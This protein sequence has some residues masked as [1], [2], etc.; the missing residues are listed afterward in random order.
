MSGEA[1]G[2]RPRK[3][4]GGRQ[5]G[6]AADHPD[7]DAAVDAYLRHLSPG[8]RRVALGR[9]R[10]VARV[11]GQ[12]EGVAGIVAARRW[13][14]LAP[15]HLA[16]VRDGLLATGA[17]P[18]TVNVTLATLRGI[19]RAA[20]D[21]GLLAA[22]TEQRLGLVRGVPIAHTPRGRLATPGEVRALF[23]ACLQ[24]HTVAGLRDAAILYSFSSAGLADAEAATL[25]V[26]DYAARPPALRIAAR[27]TAR[28]RRP[29]RIPLTGEPAAAFERW[30]AVRGSQP[31][32]LFLPLGRAGTLRG[33][34][35]TVRALAN[36]VRR[37]ARVAGLAPLTPQDLRRSAIHELFE[38]G[39]S[40]SAVWQRFGYASALTIARYDHRDPTDPRWWPDLLAGQ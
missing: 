36:V 3:G 7:Q 9:L 22:D 34:G 10:A 35:I 38:A 39:T 23:G 17:A 26:Q 13:D 21:L 12:A 31:G 19:A 20:R 16:A 37:R 40:V 1:P 32:G 18:G 24:D 11:L 30:R 25:R 27:V 29:R 4:S 15:S 8:T 6:W 28:A 5:S 2:P 33:E 14:E